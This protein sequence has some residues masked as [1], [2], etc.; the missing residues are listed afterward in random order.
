MG[1]G[2]CEGVCAQ[3][4]NPTNIRRLPHLKINPDRREE[5]IMDSRKRDEVEYMV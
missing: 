3:G 1:S 5:K 2:A 4:T